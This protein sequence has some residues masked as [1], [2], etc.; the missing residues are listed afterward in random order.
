MAISQSLTTSG[1]SVTDATS[2]ATASVAPSANKLYLLFVSNRKSGGASN[3]P[4]ASGASVTWTQVA[5]QISQANNG[6]DTV[7]R[8]LDASPGSGAITI[9]YAGDTQQNCHWAIVEVDGIDIGGTNGADAVVQTADNRPADGATSSTVTL[10]AIT[11]SS[12]ATFGM[13]SKLGLT[14]NDYTVGSG[15]TQIALIA[16]GTPNGS[17][18]DGRA[19]QVEWKAGTDNT[20]DWSFVAANDIVSI[21]LEIKAKDQSG[22]LAFM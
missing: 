11:S 3:V 15:Y 18:P 10:S 19:T 17:D 6:R 5:T 4:T 20:V 16:T 1:S 22:F 7:F 14:Q 13:S 8:S 21:G 2:Y 12:N 9:D